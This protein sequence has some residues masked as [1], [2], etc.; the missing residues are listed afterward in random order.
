MIGKY[1]INDFSEHLFWDLERSKMSI[2]ASKHSIIYKVLEYGTI[3]DWRI[4]KE[5]YGLEE[6][7][8]TAVTFRSLDPVTLAFLVN[9]FNLKKSNFRCYTNKL[10]AQNFWNS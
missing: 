7:K 10:S 1:S 2:E 8:N 3:N 6:I 4:L 5:V 9:Y